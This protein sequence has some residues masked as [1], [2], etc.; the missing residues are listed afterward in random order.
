MNKFEKDLPLKGDTKTKIFTDLPLKGD[1]EEKIDDRV[2]LPLEDEFDEHE[3]REDS[4]SHEQN[5]PGGKHSSPQSQRTTTI[6]YILMED[7]LAQVYPDVRAKEKFDSQ[8]TVYPN[9][10]DDIRV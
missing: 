3:L 5:E 2:L 4:S 9:S 1:T 8:Q 10:D 7:E 6:N